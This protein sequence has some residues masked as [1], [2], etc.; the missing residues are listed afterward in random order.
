MKQNPFRMSTDGC[1]LLFNDHIL[2]CTDVGT[3][4]EEPGVLKALIRHPDFRVR[5][6]VAAGF[7]VPTKILNMLA[8]DKDEHVLD[9]LLVGL[10]TTEHVLRRLFSRPQ[11]ITPSRCVTILERG[12]T[13]EDIVYA[14]SH[15]ESK[16]VRM[17]VKKRIWSQY[18]FR[19]Y[20]S[21]LPHS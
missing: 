1:A 9:A 13:P 20:V 2:Y 5:A 19:K 11:Y 7:G 10:S 15:H 21:Q 17:A 8:K 16:I 18:C 3:V 6:Y 4:V 14:L 12:N